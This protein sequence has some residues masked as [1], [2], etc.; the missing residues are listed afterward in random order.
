MQFS[1]IKQINKV[2]IFAK[3]C[4]L[5]PFFYLEQHLMKNK[6]QVNYSIKFYNYYGTK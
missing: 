3:F 5:V 1:K 4:W 2:M 6:K